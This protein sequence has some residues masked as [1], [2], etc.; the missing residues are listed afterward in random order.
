MKVR[1]HSMF[2]ACLRRAVWGMLYAD[3][4]GL[5]SDPEGGLAKMTTVILAVLEA[6][7]LTASKQ[8]PVRL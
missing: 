2:T 3:D 8:K 1:P 7:G 4:T 5:V 6:A